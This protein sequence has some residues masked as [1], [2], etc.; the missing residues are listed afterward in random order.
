MEDTWKN[1]LRIIE[2]EE[3]SFDTLHSERIDTYINVHNPRTQP[4]NTT[5]LTR[6]GN[7]CFYS[8]SIDFEELKRYAELKI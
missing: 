7:G 2:E 8:R 5:Y 4:Y 1:I 3:V 6:L